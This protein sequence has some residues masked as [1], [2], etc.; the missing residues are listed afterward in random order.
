MSFLH[1]ST[2]LVQ[3]PGPIS[4]GPISPGPISPGPI[5][6]ST[7]LVQ[8]HQYCIIFLLVLYYYVLLHVYQ[9]VLLQ[10]HYNI[11]T[12]LVQCHQYCIIL[13]LVLYYYVLL[14]V[15]QYV[16][17][18]F[19]YYMLVR[20]QFIINT[21]YYIISTL[22]VSHQKNSE[23]YVLM[24]S[25]V[26]QMIHQYVIKIHQYQQ[27]VFVS[28]ELADAGPPWH[29]GPAAWQHGRRLSDR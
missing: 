28:A 23:N 10:F 15:Y 21:Y 27:Y 19:H 17:L 20:C 24:A 12:S 11:S 1:I 25:L 7:S 9:Y 26:I 6:I 29:R 18:Q 3:V 14:H 13:L 8:C 2:L 22:L 4:P 5:S 16:L